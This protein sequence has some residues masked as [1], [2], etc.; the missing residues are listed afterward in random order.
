MWPESVLVTPEKFTPMNRFTCK[1]LAGFLLT[2]SVCC[3]DLL[4]SS[5]DTAADLSRWGFYNGAEF[6]GARG[7]LT[8]QAN[9]GEPGGHAVLSYD[10]TPP[11]I[12]NPNF[13]PCYVSAFTDLLTG[14]SS[15]ATGVSFLVC[16]SQPNL[17][18]QVRV[19]DATGQ[20]LQFNVDEFSGLE[21]GATDWHTAVLPD[22]TSSTI[23][24]GGAN[25]GI[26]RY[27][28]QKLS[29]MCNA[30]GLRNTG[31][32]C[33][34]EVKLTSASEIALDTFA[35]GSLPSY[36]TFSNGPEFP[37]ATG[38]LNAFP[39]YLSLLYDFTGNIVTPTNPGA[40]YVEAKRQ[41]VINGDGI[42]LKLLVTKSGLKVSVRYMD[43][44]GQ[45]FQQDVTSQYTFGN[46]DENQWVDR[47]VYFTP[48]AMHW[49]SFNDGVV[50]L[51]ITRISLVLDATGRTD[52]GELRIG[53][54]D[55]LSG[56]I[57]SL[58]IT[59][60]S[61]VKPSQGTGSLMSLTGV[62]MAF[63]DTA[64]AFDAVQG[65]GAQ[66]VRRDANWCDIE[67]SP[68]VYT[69]TNLDNFVFPAEAH[70]L[71]TVIILGYGNP[72]YTGSA[73][74]PPR[75]DSEILAFTRFAV[76]VAQRYMSHGAIFEVWNEPDQPAFWP[77]TPSATEYGALLSATAAAIQTESPGATVLSGGL[78]VPWTGTYSFLDTLSSFGAMTDVQ[79]MGMH[80]Y[81]TTSPEAQWSNLLVLQARAAE[82]GDGRLWCTELGYSS[83]N[84]SPIGNGADIIGMNAQAS[85][86]V[87][88]LLM[89]WWANLPLM[90]VYDIR[91]SSPDLLD[92]ESN[93]GLLAND[94][95]EKPAMNAVRRLLTTANGR[96][97]AGLLNPQTL[98]VGTHAAR[99]DGVS[100]KV[101]VVWV[102]ET[103]SPTLLTISNLLAKA[104]DM[105]GNTISFIPSGGSLTYLL[106]PSQG[107]IYVTIP[108]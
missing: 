38:S 64:N 68:G 66:W 87:R 50:R 48:T 12:P 54:I 4:I 25:D 8:Y 97:L 21:S 17:V 102:E 44:T 1:I 100:D 49:G 105:F 7:S 65:L 85:V 52:T 56:G 81:G 98:P 106:L 101:Y 41:G 103:G 47:V 88:Q 22:I 61:P 95:S 37:G 30:F 96:S 13:N 43:S 69:F 107:P 60:A 33:F 46:L 29:I 19:M 23:H 86:N 11:Q 26:T 28:L 3:A 14:E 5:F 78:S 58:A 93:F 71:K 24:W 55:T 45:V 99:L 89:G 90:M 75:T 57:G 76:A 15:N 35:T 104:T 18:I 91:D 80:L 53:E 36:W 73:M 2:A 83:T 82:V 40:R 10:F 51:P 27:P 70:N 74:E 67:R 16:K 34:D 92:P 63:S 59:T 108:N 42:K 32:I 94:Y 20:T 9:I 39:G 6:P 72:L 77:V 62:N 84:L 79:G 31:W